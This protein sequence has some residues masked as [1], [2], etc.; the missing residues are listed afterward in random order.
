MPN[1]C[2]NVKNQ[3][4]NQKCVCLFVFSDDDPLFCC[5][6]FFQLYVLKTVN[7]AAACISRVSEKEETSL[8][9]L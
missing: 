5:V 7:R 2:G 6:F 4:K 1:E 8:Y 3:K 9:T